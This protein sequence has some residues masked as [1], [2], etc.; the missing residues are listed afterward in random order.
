M[1]ARLQTHQTMATAAPIETTPTVQPVKPLSF[2]PG[3]TGNEPITLTA[4]PVMVATSLR[5]ILKLSAATNLALNAITKV[6]HFV[7]KT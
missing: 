4:T 1:S 3:L 2:V 7:T 5:V 6:R